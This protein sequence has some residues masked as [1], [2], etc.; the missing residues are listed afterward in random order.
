MYDWDERFGVLRILSYII[1]IFGIAL[2]L[3]AFVLCAG[4]LMG[5]IPLSYSASTKIIIAALSLIIGLVLGLGSLV[6]SLLIKTFIAI[7]RNTRYAMNVWFILEERDFGG[8]AEDVETIEESE[9]YPVDE[10]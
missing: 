5:K 10:S 8:E 6:G 4:I 1:L 2:I 9:E 3:A 7:E